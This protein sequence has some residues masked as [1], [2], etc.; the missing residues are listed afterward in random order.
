[1]SMSN[2]SFF[3]PKSEKGNAL[4]LNAGLG[5]LGVS[6]AQFLVPVVITAGVFGW[7]GGDPVMVTEGDR[8]FPIW[9]QN[10]GYVWVPFIVAS[11][12]ACWFGMNDIASA[13]ASFAEQSVIFQRK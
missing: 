1:S 10:A 5:N 13:R 8:T 3:F 7:L 6:V 4:A 2:I 11:A 12:F 9:L